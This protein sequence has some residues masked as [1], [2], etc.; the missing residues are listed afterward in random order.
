MLGKRSDQKG[1]WEADRLYLDYV[2]K[3]TFYG[4]LASL[5]GQLFSDDDFAEIYCPDNGRDSVP[6][7]LLATA[8]LLQTYDKV[9]DAEAKARAD[10]DI[11]WKVALGIEIEDRPFAKSTLQLFRA[12]LILHDKVR[13]VFEGSLRLARQ[14]GYL[15]KRGMRVALDTTYILGR[16]AVK[17]TYNL[18]ADGIVKLLRVLAVVANTTVG[19]WAEAQGYE[20]YF[21]SSIKGE[22]TIDWSD[23]KARAALLGEIVADADRLLELARQAWVELPEDSGQRQSIV[24]GAE[25]LGQLLL[26]DVERKSGDGDGDAADDDDGVSIR[27][28]VSK[29]RM[30]SVHDPE[31]RHGHKSSRR[32]FNGHKAAIVVDTDSQLITAVDVL[33][34]NAPDNLGALELVE[35]SEASTGSV[36]E[37]AMGDAAYGDGGTR[38]T[39]A[40][41]GRRLVAKVP[42]RPDRK[43]YPKND[44][45][46]DLAAGSCTCPA[47]QVTHA[48]VPAGKRTD[49]AGRVYR[50][51]AFQFDGAV[52]GVCPLRP[53]CIAA[54]GR[55][56]RRVL[57]HP[58]EGMLQQARA[59]QQSAD[60]DEYRARRVVVEHRLARL[61]QLGIRQSRYFGRVKTKFQL[62]LAATVANLTLVAGKIGLLGSTDGGAAGHRVAR[63]DV[64]AVVANAAA[65][66]SAVRLGQLWSLIL[67]TSAL[68][69]QLH[70]QIRAFR[71]LG[72][73]RGIG[74]HETAVAVGQVQHEVVH[75]PLHSANDRLPLPE[76]TLGVARRMGQRHEHLLRPPPTLPDVVLDYG[77]LTLKTV[78]I[79]ETLE[80][81]P[82]RVPLLPGNFAIAFQYRVDHA[83]EGLI[84]SLSKGWVAVVGLPAD[85]LAAP[86]V[87]HLAHR[88][89]VQA[90]RPGG[91]PNAHPLHQ[92]GPAR[93][94]IHLHCKHPLHLPQADSQPFRRRWTVQF[95]NATIRRS[96]RPRGPISRRH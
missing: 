52:C 29:D 96:S 85:S 86:R 6:P 10:F 80:D 92:A 18:L 22:A 91:F 54:Q 58:Q 61:V 35:Q 4:L 89:P 36:V 77:V 50:L 44:F 31:L 39:F 8:L 88:V 94:K 32:R 62:Y 66:F 84:L 51:Q 60:Y 20:K 74:L 41:A 69:P 3:D 73:L 79:P 46:L 55:K 87:Q 34:G 76:I 23:R 30:L 70:F 72:G 49:R 13:E 68:L 26:Q 1:L 59:L 38:Q 16:G 45:H 7:S 2:G 90:E 9:S 63:N 19:E 83:G 56:G 21:G 5:R 43:H 71:P 11:R 47:G 14:S 28:G 75:L 25:L 93:P 48:I 27:D 17:D 81:A 53:Q 65:N 67:L 33:P 78:L 24:D 12:Q 95:P 40:D 37:E 64:H 82:G 42:G 15:K 57:I